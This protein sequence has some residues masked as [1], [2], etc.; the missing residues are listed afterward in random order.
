MRSV[1]H[2]QKMTSDKT[3]MCAIVMVFFLIRSI[4]RVL[5]SNQSRIILYFPQ[6]NRPLFVGILPVCRKDSHHCGGTI[7]ANEIVPAMPFKSKF[8]DTFLFDELNHLIL[9][10]RGHQGSIRAFP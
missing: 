3:M 6:R 9:T 5:I 4:P 10:Y 2:P 1:S 7:G 8:I